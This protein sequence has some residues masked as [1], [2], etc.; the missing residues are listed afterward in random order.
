MG[1]DE[2]NIWVSELL[3]HSSNNYGQHYGQ[4]TRLE[5]K[6]EWMLAASSTGS[7]ARS[8]QSRKS[9]GPRNGN[10]GEMDSLNVNMLGSGSNDL[11]N[12]NAIL[13]NNLERDIN[14][15]NEYLD[16]VDDE[17]NLMQKPHIWRAIIQSQIRSG[18][19]LDFR[20]S[21]DRRFT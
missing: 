15:E 11:G 6:Y 14:A 17:N 20:A 4:R 3:I 12:N 19:K 1:N 7:T 2:F 5:K 13:N 16:D 9:K 21:K 18:K 8:S 10:N